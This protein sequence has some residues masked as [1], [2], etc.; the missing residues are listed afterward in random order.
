[1]F[2]KIKELL[3]QHYLDNTF[4][5]PIEH[6][7]IADKIEQLKKHVAYIEKYNT[8]FQLNKYYEQSFKQ[9]NTSQQMAFDNLNL[10]NFNQFTGIYNTSYDDILIKNY[11]FCGWGAL[12]LYQQVPLIYN[13]CKVYADEILRNGFKLISKD[14][15]DKSELINLLN[16][17]MQEYDVEKI[18]YKALITSISLGGSQIFIKLKND[19]NKQHKKINYTTQSITKNSLEYFTVIEP[20]WCSPVTTNFNKPTDNDFYKPNQYSIMGTVTHESRLIKTIFNEVPNLLKPVYWFYGMSLTQK[21]INAVRDVE[22]IKQE[23]KEIIKRYNLCLIG[24]S[25]DALADPISAK[26]RIKSFV[27]GRDNWGAFIYAKNEEEVQQIQM[28]INGLNDLLTSYLQLIC[29]ASQIPATKLFG[30]PPSGFSNSDESSHRNFFDLIDNC[31]YSMGKPSIL[32]MIYILMLNEGLEIDYGIDIE[33]GKLYEAN[34]LELAQIDEFKSKAELNRVNA[35]IVTVNE[36]R[37]KLF[38]DQDNDF[39]SLEVDDL[40]NFDDD[41]NNE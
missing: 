22:E 31:R 13:A 19:E 41:I 26:A 23:I 12:T 36:I 34:K 21:I 38:T 7:I 30:T 35:G 14:G 18:L 8:E 2:K 5:N 11:Q 39:T 9:Q 1:M 28:S 15:S 25:A 6:E 20:Q 40:D 17:R 32:Q 37:Q 27:N 10:N 29:P 4:R 3:K 16:K 33:F 24:L